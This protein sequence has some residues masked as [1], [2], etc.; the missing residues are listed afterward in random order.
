MKVNCDLVEVR[1]IDS[2][3]LA[4]QAGGF[5][6]QDIPIGTVVGV[7]A[8][9]LIFASELEKARE[10]MLARPN[11]LE[12]PPQLGHPLL[13]IVMQTNY[14][15]VL[16]GDRSRETVVKRVL[17]SLHG[18]KEELIIIPYPNFG[19]QCMSVNAANEGEHQNCTYAAITYKGFPYIFLL[20]V[21]DIRKGDELLTSYGNDFFQ[22]RDHCQ[23][24][25]PGLDSLTAGMSPLSRPPLN[26]RE[27]LCI[28]SQQIFFSSDPK[29]SRLRHKVEKAWA[30]ENHFRSNQEISIQWDGEK[31]AGIH[32]KDVKAAV[33]A[34]LDPE[35]SQ[36][37]ASRYAKCREEEEKAAQELDACY[38]TLEVSRDWSRR[39]IETK[40][41]RL[42]LKYHPDKNAEDVEHASQRFHEIREAECKLKTAWGL[43]FQKGTKKSRPLP[44]Q[45][46][47][48]L[49]ERGND[50]EG[51]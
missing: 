3:P 38:K 12:W 30:D 9:Q 45:R 46:R 6:V 21:E 19:G 40:I 35:G 1:H 37:G 14:E 18:P 43:Q 31:P 34:W 8:G 20:A 5:A 7:Y 44:K 41:K 47:A 28:K 27:Q 13:E 48:A 15:M 25:I 4:G 26:W 2:G 36:A 17:R 49:L 16:V 10:E 29:I 42:L 33:L 11:M 22:S 23:Y 39:E 50:D 32:E 51:G 24:R